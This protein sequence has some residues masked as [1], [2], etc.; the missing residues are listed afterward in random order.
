MTCKILALLLNTL[1]EDEKYPVLNTD[2]LT[3]PIQMQSS[4]KE[5]KFSQFFAGFFKS[6][7]NLECFDS[8]DDPHTFCISDT[9]DS[10]NVVR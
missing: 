10:E 8:K 7:W 6:I 9:T 4:D 2:N 5:K 3:I 1:A